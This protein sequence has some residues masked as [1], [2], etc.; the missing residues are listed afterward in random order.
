[1]RFGNKNV[2]LTRRRSSLCTFR[3]YHI[4]VAP[5]VS[6]L[7]EKFRQRVIDSVFRVANC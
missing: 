3:P 6:R 4:G 2:G 7:T 1:M 5:R